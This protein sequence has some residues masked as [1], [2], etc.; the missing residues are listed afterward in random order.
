MARLLQLW[1]R[2]CRDRLH[3][4]IRGCIGRSESSSL[5][6][7]GDRL[8]VTIESR[9]VR[10]IP[11]PG[12]AYSWRIFPGFEHLFA[13]QLSSVGIRECREI[14]AHI[15]HGFEVVSRQE[16]E[17]GDSRLRGIR[18]GFHG[19]PR[20]GGLVDE[21]SLHGLIAM[22]AQYRRDLRRLVLGRTLEQVNRLSVNASPREVVH[23]RR[24]C[25][26]FIAII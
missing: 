17:E 9:R 20:G 1:R 15:D 2:R 8:G 18:P 14:I 11:G 23:I 6:I 24:T 5:T 3:S 25:R 16:A 19:R 22:M 26:K 12:D 7:K 21:P 13:R 4:H 10:L